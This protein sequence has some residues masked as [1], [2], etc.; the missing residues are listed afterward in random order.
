VVWG[1][2]TVDTRGLGWAVVAHTMVD[3]CVMSAFFVPRG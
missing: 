2:L 3:V 1:K